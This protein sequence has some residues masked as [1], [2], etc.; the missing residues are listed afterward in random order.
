MH[1]RI[2]HQ[3]QYSRG[4]LLLRSFFGIFYLIIPHAFVLLFVGLAGALLS[5]L[6]F[7]IILFTGEY[8]KNWFD[9]Q[10]RLL[11]WNIRVNASVYNLIDGYPAFGLSATHPNVD[12]EVPYP[13]NLNRGTL[14]IKTLFS[15]IYVLIPHVFLLYFRLI[16]GAI[17]SF[18]SWWSVLFT[19]TYPRNWHHF[20]VGNI[21]WST[22]LS[23]FN[24]NMNQ[25]YPAFTG[26]ELPEESTKY[27]GKEV[28]EDWN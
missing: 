27:D 7:W 13:E 21:R 8:P 3:A 4:E 11:R 1:L 9:F 14:I 17:L 2:K 5:F 26:R 6:T 24:L 12:F 20:M 15:V 28:W 16:W 19:G 10:V 25:R 22:R 18:L 23:V